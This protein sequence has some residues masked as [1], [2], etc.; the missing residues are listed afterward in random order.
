MS[1][2]QIIRAWKDEGYRRSLSRKQQAKLPPNPAGLV[3]LTDADL[4][5]V[6]GGADPDSTAVACATIVVSI[7]TWTVSMAFTCSLACA[8]SG[9]AEC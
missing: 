6:P 1:N 8:G 7:I 9:C 5:L 4:G 3:E 2:A